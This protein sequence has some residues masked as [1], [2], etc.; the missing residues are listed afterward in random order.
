MLVDR[1][2]ARSLGWLLA[3]FENAVY[4]LS[5]MWRVNAFDQWGVERGKELTRELTAALEGRADASER[6]ASTQA[7]IR[8]YRDG[9]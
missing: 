8:R 9:S 2:D 7:L 6:D 1:L 3:S 4:A 5:V